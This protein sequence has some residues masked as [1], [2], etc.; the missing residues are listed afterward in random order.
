MAHTD[1]HALVALYNATD[2]PNWRNN[3]NWITGA[4]LS[5]WYGVNVNTQGRVVEL[6]LKFNNLRGTESLLWTSRLA[7]L[8]CL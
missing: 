2:G 1:R 8:P 6:S 3:S 7:L 5:Q 4:D